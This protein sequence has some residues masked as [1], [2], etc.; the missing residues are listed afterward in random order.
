M[1]VV[2]SLAGL[3]L[4]F[5]D[6][7]LSLVT[8]GDE[9]GQRLDNGAAGAPVW[10]LHAV[11]AEG[12]R[13][14]LHGKHAASVRAVAEGE[15]LRLE[16]R[17]VRDAAT[18]A[19]PFD[20]DV[21]IRAV[22]GSESAGA[23]ARRHGAS[24]ERASVPAHADLAA[25]A[26]RIAV[27]NQSSEWTLWHVTFPQLAGILPKGQGESDAFFHP[28]GWGLL[29]RGWDQ[30]A[31]TRRRYPRG[32]DCA[33]Q[34]I[35]YTAGSATWYVAAH[36]PELRTRDFWF[37]PEKGEAGRRVRLAWITYPEDMTIPGN[38]FETTWDT[39]VALVPGDWWDA[40]R[41][42]RGWANEQAW[43]RPP[44]GAAAGTEPGP[45]KRGAELPGG[46]P[47]VAAASRATREIH[48][49]QVLQV[50]EKPMDQWAAEMPEIQARLGVRLGIQIYNWH[51]IP[52]DISYPDY[53]PEKPGFREFVA[54]LNG[55]GLL[56]MPY[57]NG[58][59]WDVNAKSWPARGAERFAV[60]H[61]A[62]RARPVSLIPYLEDYGSGQKLAPMCAHTEFWQDTVTEL[63]RR[64]VHELGCGG[65]YVDQV[66]AEKGELCCNPAHGHPLGGGAYWLAGYRRLAAKVR[67]AIG[68]EPYLT[69]ECNWEGAG[70]DYDALL[71]W[72][73]FTDQDIPLFPSVYAGLARS[74]G[75]SFSAAEVEENGGERFARKMGQL[76]VWGAQLGWGDLTVLLKPANAPQLRFFAE[77]CRLRR[78]HAALFAE[79][80]LLRPPARLA[81]PAALQAAVWQH[82]GRRVL[83]AVNP[84]AAPCEARLRLDSG[85]EVPLALPAL[86]AA[87]RAVGSGK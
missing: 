71:S 39:I 75:L 11:D 40:A 46:P 54:K 38:G 47:S 33:M 87:A 19:G 55:A 64:I 57:I 84:Q 24:W 6:A 82:A 69:T 32:W 73:W 22:P 52:F 25:M 17:G 28:H 66:A 37:R 35:G 36:D 10:Q 31:E 81:G 9:A 65:V 85:A 30:F 44:P 56:T 7:A 58:R 41:L 86:A 70:G 15:A 76:F 8:V 13:A 72:A 23:E 74:Y 16:W 60:K 21:T 3:R 2:H 51:Q 45:P 53:F 18:G 20:V 29:Q 77:L 61:S 12:R 80:E 14:D 63:C 78:E 5:E 42:Y 62:E 48:A 50:P 43:L 49:W 1:A 68:P 83:F 4:E 34:F 26:W 79:G 59:L 27:R 67:A